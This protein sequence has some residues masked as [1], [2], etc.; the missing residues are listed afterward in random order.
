MHVSFVKT[1][2]L[3]STKLKSSGTG[4]TFKQGLRIMETS[5][6]PNERDHPER[7]LVEKLVQSVATPTCTRHERPNIERSQ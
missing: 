3:P 4:R 7:L 6:I 2:R 5:A 1:I